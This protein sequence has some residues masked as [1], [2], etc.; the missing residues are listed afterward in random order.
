MPAAG[1]CLDPEFWG[2]KQFGNVEVMSGMR[3]TCK[4][5]LSPDKAAE[6]MSQLMSFLRKEVAFA[7]E[8]AWEES[9]HMTAV[10]WW[11]AWGAEVP[12]LQSVALKVL[13]QPVSVGGVER[14]WSTFG[15]IQSKLRNKMLPATAKKLVMVHMWLRIE[16]MKESGKW[17]ADLL[18]HTD[19][20][21]TWEQ[22]TSLDE[23]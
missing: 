12:E 11:L 22:I 20:D 6:A 8:E 19:D 2:H 7:Q 21:L 13:S 23:A 14:V 1:Y 15:W 4:K 17:E 18:Q 10:Q 3:A 5:L 9:K 16:T